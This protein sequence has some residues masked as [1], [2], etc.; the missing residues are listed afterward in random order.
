MAQTSNMIVI[1]APADAIWQVLVDFGAADRYLAGVVDCT[2][3]GEGIGALRTLTSVDGSTITER[4]DVLDATAQRL[5]YALLTDTP[6]GNCLTTV[7]VRDLGPNV[8]ELAW[9]ATFQPDGIPESE[10]VVLLEGALED[11]CLAMKQF[12]ENERPT[13]FNPA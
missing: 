8:A 4:L 6:F 12:M 5:S 11:N 10:A 2:A 3:E 9:S 13:D 1:N 7:A